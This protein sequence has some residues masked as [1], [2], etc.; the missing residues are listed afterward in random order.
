MTLV[1][2][3]DGLYYMFVKIFILFGYKLLVDLE[4]F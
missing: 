1:L 2:I 3:I 4:Q